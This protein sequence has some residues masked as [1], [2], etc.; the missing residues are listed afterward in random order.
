MTTPG[1]PPA[2]ARAT[3]WYARP[4][5]VLT[6]L[7]VLVLASALLSRERVS[8]RSGDPRLSAYSAQP[9]GARLLYET[10]NRLGWNVVR[11]R[12]NPLPRSDASI[13]ALLDPPDMIRPADA[14]AI[15][16]FVRAGGGLLLALGQGTGSLADS[17]RVTPAT[18]SGVVDS[19]VLSDACS[20]VSRFNRDGL[21]IGAATLIPITGRGL[22]AARSDTLLLVRV[23][24]SRRRA[25]T[26]RPAI[27][28]MPYGRGR[29]VV[30]A[31]PDVFRN[32]ALRDCRFGLDVPAVRALEYLRDGGP[33]RRST[34]VFDEF[35][36]GGAR[37]AGV[38]GAVQRYLADTRSGHA[39]LQLSIA[40]IVLLLAMAPRLL[41]P[42]DVSR[43][44]R[45]S[46][47][48]HV[49][50][51]ARAYEQVRAS[52]TATSRLVRGLRR[53]VQ[54]GSSRTRTM[55]SDE[56]FLDRVAETMPTIAADVTIV[57]S[58]LGE[59]L[60]P[61]QFQTVGDAIARIEDKLTRP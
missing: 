1:L 48:E 25:A 56:A 5:V 3:P 17:L 29:I 31:D 33:T 30:A 32:D 55:E 36:Q 24:G 23:G 11:T 8:G 53:R 42:R 4:R 40:G 22:D 14:H 47:L 34:L 15:L 52:R 20:D 35:H 9:L 41:V 7:V 12:S 46:P 44:E 16:E 27:V 45:R 37:R 49:D 18:V 26:F 38:G 21:W 28:A 51:L 60:E 50:A 43:M 58:A 61:R 2:T 10:A 13:V 19:R 57:R 6:S 54:R 59:S 39:L